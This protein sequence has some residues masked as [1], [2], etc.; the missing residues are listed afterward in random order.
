[1]METENKETQ[2]SWKIKAKEKSIKIKALQKE[3]KRLQEQSQRYRS[4][5]KILRLALIEKTAELESISRKRA[6]TVFQEVFQEG[7]LKKK[8]RRVCA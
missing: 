4:T 6:E 7:G 5:N 8:I 3:K 1:M 2:K